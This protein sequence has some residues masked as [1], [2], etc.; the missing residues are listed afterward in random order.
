MQEYCNVF[1]GEGECFEAG[2]RVVELDD[3]GARKNRLPGGVVLC[4]SLLLDVRND[5]GADQAADPRELTSNLLVL[6][7]DRKSFPLQH[8]LGYVE[9]IR[10]EE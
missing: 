9:V 6:Y 2:M 7:V 4:G 3:V 1:D 5:V 8:L 10:R